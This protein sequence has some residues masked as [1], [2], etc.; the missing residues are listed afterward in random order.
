P[1]WNV[2]NG[3]YDLFSTTNLVPSWW[4]WVLR[5]APGQTNITLTNMPLPMEFFILGLTNDTDG[6]G[7]SD[8]YEK[9]LGLNTSDPNDDHTN[10]IVSISVTDSVAIEQEPT[11][12]ASFTITRLGGHMKWPLVIPIQLSGT[13]TL[14]V[15]YSLSPVT[16]T[17]S[18]VLVIIPTNTTS[19]TVTLTPIDD[20]V[21]DGTKTA[22]LIVQAG[23]GWSVD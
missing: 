16:V 4:N 9:L 11:N 1:P 18:N 23:S 7:L 2:T 20:H 8:A 10:P 15:N 21:A 3:V 13:A 17:S 6:G 22:T 5:C 19:V 14:G 12:T